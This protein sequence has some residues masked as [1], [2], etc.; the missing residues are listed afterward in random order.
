MELVSPTQHS[1]HCSTPPGCFERSG[2]QGITNICRR[3]RLENTT[4]YYSAVSQGQRD[5]S[6]RHKVNQPVATLCKLAP[7]PTCSG[8]GRILNRLESA[9]RLCIPSVQHHPTYLK[10]SDRRQCE[11][12][13]CSTSLANSTLV[14]T[15]TT[16]HGETPCI[17]SKI[18]NSYGRSIKP[19]VNPANAPETLGLIVQLKH[20]SVEKEAQAIIEAVRHWK[21]FLTGRHFTL[22]T[23]QKSVSYMFDQR[24]RTKIKNDKIMRW[25]LELS[26]YSFDIVYRP[27]KD[28][29]PPDT[30]SRAT[31]ASDADGSLYKL[32]ESLCHP[33]LPLRPNQKPAL[34]VGRDQETHQSM[35]CMLLV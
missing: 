24:H 1:N 12:A 30:L 34:R 31:C 11:H 4:S 5:R 25:R 35:S 14:A 2:R 6:F 3:E 32:H 26:C 29:V 15:P 10:E 18:P 16:T 28:N 7:R 8:N 21:H 19:A 22:K 33:T 23:N 9:E 13:T 27:G 20:S 17:T